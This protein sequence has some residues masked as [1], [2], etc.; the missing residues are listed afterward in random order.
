MGEPVKDTV[1]RLREKLGGS[2][3]DVHVHSPKRLYVKVD[4]AAIR[5]VALFMRDAGIRFAIAT[6]IDT[7]GGFEILYHFDN[8]GTG[9]IITL[10]V[11]ITDKENPEIDSIADILQAADWIE[12]EMWEMLGITFRGHADMRRLL[13]PDDWPQGVYPLRTDFLLPEHERVVEINNDET[14]NQ[15]PE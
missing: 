11:L 8:D 4:P 2:I 5:Q 1:E 6:G 10:Q 9:K 13:L 7:P 12:R 3:L 15:K 14:R